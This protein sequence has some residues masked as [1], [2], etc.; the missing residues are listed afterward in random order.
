MTDDSEDMEYLDVDEGISY[1]T[2][3]AKKR[4]KKDPFDLMT[5]KFNKD[6]YDVDDL[7]RKATRSASPRFFE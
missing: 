3:S 1:F 6:T 5:I 4:P 2:P 7:I